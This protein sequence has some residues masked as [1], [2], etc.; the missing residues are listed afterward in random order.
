MDRGEIS[1]FVAATGFHLEDKDG[2]HKNIPKLMEDIFR[3]MAFVG[4][5]DMVMFSDWVTFVLQHRKCIPH[6]RWKQL[7]GLKKAPGG[8]KS[9]VLE[10]VS[11][12]NGLPKHMILV[13]SDVKIGS[14]I[15]A[16]SFGV[17]HTRVFILGIA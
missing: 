7:L 3:K 17:G 14:Q 9:S 13:R 10:H 15:G 5:N 4:L 11:E 8:G 6:E 12:T 2:L 1:A 16:G